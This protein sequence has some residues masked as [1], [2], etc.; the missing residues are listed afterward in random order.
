MPS[1]YFHLFFHLLVT[2]LFGSFIT[3]PVHASEKVLVQLKDGGKVIGQLKE[4]K[5]DSV[6]IKTKRMEISLNSDQIQ[7]IQYMSTGT[8]INNKPPPPGEKQQ[9]SVIDHK[10]CGEYR[11]LCNR[12]LIVL[13]VDPTLKHFRHSAPKEMCINIGRVCKELKFQFQPVER[14]DFYYNYVLQCY[15]GYLFD[16]KNAVKDADQIAGPQQI[17]NWY[18]SNAATITT[19]NDTFTQCLENA[20]TLANKN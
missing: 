5:H 15:K 13:S 3:S 17:A 19:I 10:T 12:K 20:E 1:K 14:L 7:S 9:S 18:T 2:I 11:V 16:Y 8:Q 4:K 6:T